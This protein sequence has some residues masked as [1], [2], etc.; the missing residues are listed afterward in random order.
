[1]TALTD[2][3]RAGDH[4]ADLDALDS[5]VKERKTALSVTAG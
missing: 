5:A 3:I 1:M 2:A 4:D